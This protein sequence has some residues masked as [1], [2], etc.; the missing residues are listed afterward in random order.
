MKLY[1]PPKI[2]GHT[3]LNKD[4]SRFFGGLFCNGGNWIISTVLQ[5][6]DSRFIKHAFSRS[7]LAQRWNTKV[8]SASLT[9]AASFIVEL[10]SLIYIYIYIHE[11][12][13]Y[14]WICP[15]VRSRYLHGRNRNLVAIGLGLLLKLKLSLLASCLLHEIVVDEAVSSS[16]NC[17]THGIE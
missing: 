10:I 16:K 9:K 17:R 5:R 2:A 8:C 11:F 13:I 7:N 14:R 12:V 6:S 1:H 4:Q 3:A 15:F